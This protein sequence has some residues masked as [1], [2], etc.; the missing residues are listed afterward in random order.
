MPLPTGVIPSAARS[1]SSSTSTVV[2]A[3]HFAYLAERTLPEGD[4]LARLKAAAGQAGIPEI[5]VAPEQVAL[6]AILLRLCHAK[7]VVVIG[8]VMRGA[9][10]QHS[11][12]V[13][14]HDRE[15]TFAGCNVNCR[16]IAIGVKIQIQKDRNICSGRRT[17]TKRNGNS[18]GKEVLAHHRDLDENVGLAISG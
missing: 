12:T 4:F 8:P 16:L 13:G 14:T 3:A 7:R 18:D 9:A 2:S 1:L 6:M 15:N 10:L 17:E 11:A 5:C